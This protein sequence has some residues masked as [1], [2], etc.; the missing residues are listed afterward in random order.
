M[1]TD[2]ERLL[3]SCRARLMKY[4][5]AGVGKNGWTYKEVG[6]QAGF[7]WRDLRALVEAN[8]D[9]VRCSAQKLAMLERTLDRIESGQLEKVN[10]QIVERADPTRRP[11]IVH[12]LQFLTSGRPV[13]RLTPA[14]VAAVEA[15]TNVFKKRGLK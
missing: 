1:S 10:G 9:R 3:T 6:E 11:S 2:R 4:P 12:H 7:Y 15:L 13:I 5:A 8:Y 14:P